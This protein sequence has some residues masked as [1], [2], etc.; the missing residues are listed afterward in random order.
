MIKCPSWRT[1]PVAMC[2]Y[3]WAMHIINC[4]YSLLNMSYN[5][6]SPLNLFCTYV[7]IRTGFV[8]FLI[9]VAPKFPNT[10]TRDEGTL[11]YYNNKCI[12][13]GYT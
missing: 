11:V 2:Y 8:K 5:P 1:N 13:I 6:S 4:V 7:P 9:S 3:F 12:V 10:V